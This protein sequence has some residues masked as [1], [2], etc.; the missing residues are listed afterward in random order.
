[1]VMGEGWRLGVK[2]NQYPRLKGNGAER[3]WLSWWIF[4]CEEKTGM[5]RSVLFLQY[6][7]MVAWK[8][9]YWSVLIIVRGEL[10]W[11]S[12]I[13]WDYTTAAAAWRQHVQ[14]CDMS[15]WGYWNLFMCPILSYFMILSCMLMARHEH[16][17]LVS[18]VFYF[19]IKAFT[20]M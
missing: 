7:L 12:T 2:E 20:S 13:N 1:M 5:L 19:W 11:H 9:N 10:S 14:I 3:N 17:W 15:S 4:V 6:F 16:L 8:L 18:L